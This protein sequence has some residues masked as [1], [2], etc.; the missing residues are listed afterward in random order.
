MKPF[1]CLP[2][3]GSPSPVR[4]CCSCP[5]RFGDLRKKHAPEYWSMYLADVVIFNDFRAPQALCGCVAAACGASATS[6][7]THTWIFG[8]CILWI[9]SFLT[10]LGPLEPFAAVSQLPAALRRPRK[11][12]PLDFGSMHLVDVVDSCLFLTTLGSP[13]WP[14]RRND[15]QIITKSRQHTHEITMTWRHNDEITTK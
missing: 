3:L 6:T 12:T 4:L 9:L 11:N 15:D 8:I 10:I 7:N 2:E 13:K 5:W 14:W 1:V